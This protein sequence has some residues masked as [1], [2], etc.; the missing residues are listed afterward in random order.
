MESVP[1]GTKA[2]AHFENGIPD[3]VVVDASSMRTSGKRICQS[4]HEK[5]TTLPIVLVIDQ[6]GDPNDHFGADALLVLPFT[7]QKLVNKVRHLLP[8]QNEG[9]FVVGALMLDIEQH[10]AILEERQ[11]QL[12]PRLVALLKIL[13]EHP[14]EVMYR[15]D[16]FRQAW[17]T[18]YTGDTR[19][20]DVHMSWLRRAI[21][22]N[23]RH[24]RFIKTVRGVGYRLD[25]ET[26]TKPGLRKI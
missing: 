9:G 18:D 12:T 21:E 19:S 13:M 17:E 14:G 11:I 6:N 3:L 4:L 2:L 15:E 1:S 25:I 24:P 16:L 23:P 7:L 22:E 20:L 8:I 10:R 5:K 26:Q